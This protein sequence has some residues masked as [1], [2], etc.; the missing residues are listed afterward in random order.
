MRAI[1]I[2]VAI[3]LLALSASSCALIGIDHWFDSGKID[4]NGQYVPKEEKFKLKDKPNHII[5]TN[6][7]ILNIYRRV[8]M[9]YSGH[10]VYPNNNYHTDNTSYSSLNQRVAYIKFHANGRSSSFSIPAKDE[11][12]LDSNLME[13][14]LNPNNSESSK[15]YYF[16]KNGKDIQIESFVHGEGYGMYV[17]FDYFLNETG[18]TLKMVYENSVHVYVKEE[19][20][21]DW[22]EYMI[23]W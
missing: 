12:G 1:K 8:E 13:K 19:L 16:S 22:K 15:N 11:Y 17:I 7:D 21:S 14:D 10:M 5:P 18:D 6:L 3:I 23:D 9:Y 20:P 4:Q 2:H